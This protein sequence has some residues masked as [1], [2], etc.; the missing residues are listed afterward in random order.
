MRFLIL[1]NYFYKYTLK[2]ETKNQLFDNNNYNY[3]CKLYL[4]YNN[5]NNK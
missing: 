5:N 1:I 4:I 2:L 3:F